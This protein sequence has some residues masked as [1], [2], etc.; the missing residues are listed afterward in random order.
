MATVMKAPPSTTNKIVDVPF[1]HRKFL[2]VEGADEVREVRKPRVESD[3][4]HGTIRIG[5]QSRGASQPAT[6][7]VLMRRD[8]NR[9]RED[10]KKLIGT[11]SRL[12]RHRRERQ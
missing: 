10:S 11:E 5:Q 9:V 7:K 1:A 2:A 8:A 6:N 3:I 4:G 12:P